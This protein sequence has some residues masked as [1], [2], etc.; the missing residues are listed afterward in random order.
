MY[1]GKKRN[2]LVC[3]WILPHKKL[4]FLIK[5]KDLRVK[6]KTLW[7]NSQWWHIY[8]I[9]THIDQQTVRRPQCREI[10][11][12]SLHDLLPRLHVSSLQRFT[13]HWLNLIFR[14]KLKLIKLS[15]PVTDSPLDWGHRRS[16][17]QSPWWHQPA[18]PLGPERRARKNNREINFPP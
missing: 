14:L 11:T 4:K 10:K 13:A 16:S 8:N 3:L 9:Q 7:I 17:E 15:H 1:G 5:P 18:G 6:H 2:T 12:S